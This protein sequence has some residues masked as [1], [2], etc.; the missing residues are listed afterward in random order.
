[1][2]TG[3][4]RRAAR[5]R[6][7]SKSSVASTSA[8]TSEIDSI[9]TGRPM[10]RLLS[11]RAVEV[12]VAAGARPRGSCRRSHR[13]RLLRSSKV[14]S[15]RRG[16]HWHVCVTTAGD[17]GT[18][19]RFFPPGPTSPSRRSRHSAWPVQAGRG[20]ASARHWVGGRRRGCA[21]TSVDGRSTSRASSE[22]TTTRS[23]PPLGRPGFGSTTSRTPRRACRWTPTSSPRSCPRCSGTAR[24]A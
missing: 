4:A 22:G 2:S 3:R 23:W 5:T 19:E 24:S 9:T 16:D 17:R 8:S 1:M 18:Q 11:V 10:P 15:S 13:H 7:I 14:E 20:P 12:S 6:V 21:L